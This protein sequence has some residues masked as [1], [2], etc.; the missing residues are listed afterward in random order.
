MA[1]GKNYALKGEARERERFIFIR[2]V[3]SRKGNCMV[4]RKRGCLHYLGMY[5]VWQVVFSVTAALLVALFNVE[6][7]GA[8]AVPGLFVATIATYFVFKQRRLR[9]RNLAPDEIELQAAKLEA[10]E[11]RRAE[12]NQAISD[13]WYNLC[14]YVRS[15]RRLRQEARELR[16][17]RKGE[18][19]E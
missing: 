13:W 16:G 2:S 18:V 3:V 12:R 15:R 1:S 19:D 8:A 17:K 7:P 9:T 10:R 14:G 4:V 11:R 5:L 6:E